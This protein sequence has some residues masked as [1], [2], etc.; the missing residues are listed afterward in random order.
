MTLI[1]ELNDKFAYYLEMTKRRSMGTVEG[2]HRTISRLSTWLKENRNITNIQDVTADDIEA[3]LNTL[4]HPPTVDYPTGRPYE[5]TTR[6][7]MIS[8]I[9]HFFEWAVKKKYLEFDV[10]QLIEYPSLKEQLPKSLS[11]EDAEKL[12]ETAKKRK[13]A[14]RDYL[15]T[16]IFL[17]L[18]VRVSELV[19]MNEEDINEST[20]EVLI[21]GKGNKERRLPLTPKIVQALDA[22]RPVRRKILEIRKRKDEPALFISEKRGTRLT[23]RGAELIIEE[24]A[25]ESGIKYNFNVSPHKLRHTAATILYNDGEADLLAISELLGHKDPSTS[26]IYTKV[27]REK[28]RNVIQSNPLEGI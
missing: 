2:Y 13:L 12:M 24:I 14:E 1:D 26:K 22:Y 7:A 11:V 18:G 9:R 27:N 20:G 21:R 25:K 5:A 8:A 17:T 3:F 23:R 6:A 16:R 28:L 19:G 10:S 15:M 4:R